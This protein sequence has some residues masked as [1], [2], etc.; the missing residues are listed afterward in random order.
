MPERN[1]PNRTN[2]WLDWI[3]ILISV[4]F[5]ISG[6]ITLPNYGISWDE[7]LG[8]FFFGNRYAQ[9]ITSGFDPIYLDFDK[10]FGDAANELDLEAYSP[11]RDVYYEFPGFIDTLSGLSMRFF[12]YQLGWMDPVDAFHAVTILLAALYFLA[13]Y[14]YVSRLFDQRLAIISIL[15]LATAPRFWGDAHFNP[16]DVPESVFF[17][18]TL[19]SFMAW[20]QKPTIRQATLVGIF[21]GFALGV[22]ANA[23]FLPVIIL[24]W[25]ALWMKKPGAFLTGVREIIHHWLHVG[26]MGFSA[27]L[28]Y[29]FS[30]PLLYTSPSLAKLYF[31]YIFSQGGR[32]GK[33]EWSLQPI[34]MVLAGNSEIFIVALIIGLVALTILHYKKGYFLLRWGMVVLWMFIPITRISAPISVNFDGFRHFLEY[35]PAASIIAAFGVVSVYDRIPQRVRSGNYLLPAV[36]AS[37]I[38]LNTF[39][40]FAKVNPYQYIY[41]NRFFGGAKGAQTHFKQG[42]ATDYWAIGY[43]DGMRWLNQNAGSNALLD[44][45]IGDY[46]VTIP[47]KLWLREDIKLISDDQIDGYRGTD[48]EVYIMN[49]TRPSFYKDVAKSCE[50]NPPVYSQVVDGITVMTIHDLKNCQTEIK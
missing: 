49:I 10:N 14:Y 19:L 47:A 28:A 24:L 32:A 36:F 12:G 11:Y 29:F 22:K 27:A 41:F 6:I 20:I 5:F 18:L 8:N 2:P 17:G 7:G 33:G 48:R 23:V 15:F 9:Y 3:A 34:K 45:P 42:E 26:L 1:N 43:R 37:L 35:L 39:Y 25:I 44:A 31:Q 21:A 40:I 38:G 16:K 46:L 4:S 30:W 50:G 13:Q